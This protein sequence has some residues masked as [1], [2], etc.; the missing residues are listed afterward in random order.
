[1]TAVKAHYVV[2]R[3]EAA[4]AENGHGYLASTHQHRLFLGLFSEAGVSACVC[5][6]LMSPEITQN[7]QKKKLFSDSF[8]ESIKKGLR[9]LVW[10]SILSRFYY[11]HDP[12]LFLKVLTL[13]SQNLMLNRI[14]FTEAQ[15][16]KNVSHASKSQTTMVQFGLYIVSIN[17]INV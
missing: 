2:S 14:K 17:S 6:V 8:Q 1:M 11:N 13:E 10:L 15:T 16:W 4:R 3:S 5:S 9:A 12:G 7:A